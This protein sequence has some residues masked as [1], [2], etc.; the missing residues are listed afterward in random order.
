MPRKLIIVR[1]AHRDK[2]KPLG[3]LADNGLSKKGKAQ[4][5]AVLAHFLKVQETRQ[6]KLISSPKVRCVETLAPLAKRLKTKIE[7]HPALDEQQPSQT[8]AAYQKSIKGFLEHWARG[9]QGVTVICSHG[10]WIPRALE[11][12]VGGPIELKKGGWAE[13]EQ[14]GHGLHLVWLLQRL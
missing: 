11:I 14:E 3:R 6:V 2:P 10:D 7:I 12:I 9:R 8:E 1:H 5:K 4:A 13:I